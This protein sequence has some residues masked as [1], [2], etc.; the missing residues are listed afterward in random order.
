[1]FSIACMSSPFAGS[2]NVNARTPEFGSVQPGLLRSHPCQLTSFN[3]R[4]D[5]RP[6]KNSSLRKA[7]CVTLKAQ[8]YWVV[9][10]EADRRRNAIAV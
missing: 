9:R 2:A 6:C 7:S 4:E 8:L 10:A 3:P 1:M 5:K